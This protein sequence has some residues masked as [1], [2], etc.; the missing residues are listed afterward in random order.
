MKD[1]SFAVLVYLLG[2][3]VAVFIAG[4]IKIILYLIRKFTNKDVAR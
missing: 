3:I 1:I 2:F 4:L